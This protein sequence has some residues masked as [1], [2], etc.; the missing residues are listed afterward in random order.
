MY[1]PFGHAT[2][3]SPHIHFSNGIQQLGN[4]CKPESSLL[5]ALWSPV[6]FFIGIALLLPISALAIQAYESDFD[7]DRCDFL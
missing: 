2:F 1:D 5:K 3:L 4:N 6:E 7:D